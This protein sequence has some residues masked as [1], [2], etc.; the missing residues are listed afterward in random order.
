MQSHVCI[1]KKRPDPA[2]GGAL[3]WSLPF[4]EICLCQGVVAPVIS[5]TCPEKD[6][7]QDS[8]GL[9]F[10]DDHLV[11]E[12]TMRHNWKKNKMD[13]LLDRIEFCGKSMNE[14]VKCHATL[15]F[16]YPIQCSVQTLAPL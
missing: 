10:A 14:E 5:K 4:A 9:W 13:E 12:L 11:Y 6:D 2:R 8:N 7:Y 16:L 1:F 15:V 3:R